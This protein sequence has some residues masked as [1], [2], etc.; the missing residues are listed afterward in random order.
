MQLVNKTEKAPAK[1]PGK[2]LAGALVQA[3][4]NPKMTQTKDNEANNC[5]TKG[6][7]FNAAYGINIMQG[8]IEY[9]W[10]IA[11]KQ[12]NCY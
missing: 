8:Y 7:N 3:K 12:G 11:G 1:K 9:P 4:L 5:D 6:K 10:D 2:F